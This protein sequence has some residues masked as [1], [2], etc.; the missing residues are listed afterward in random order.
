MNEWMFG[1]LKSVVVQGKKEN[2]LIFPFL[3]VFFFSTENG[4]FMVN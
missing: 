2:S 3:F 1:L 4:G